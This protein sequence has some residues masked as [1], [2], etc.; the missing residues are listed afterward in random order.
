MVSKNRSFA[1]ALFFKR[2][3]TL[4]KFAAI[5]YKPPK[6]Q[7][8]AAIQELSALIEE[9]CLAGAKIIVC[10]EMATTGYI[11]S[12]PEELLPYTETVDGPLFQALSTLARTH[13]AWIVCGYAEREEENLYNAAMVVDS[14]GGLVCSYRKILLY[15]A[16]YTWSKSG[17]TRYL[18]RT[19]YGTLM[20]AICMDLNDNNLIRALWR[21]RPDI[22]AFCTNWLDEGTEVLPYWQTRLRGWNGVF[23]AANSWGPDGE[24]SFCGQSAILSADGSPAAQAGRSGNQILYAD[25]S[26]EPARLY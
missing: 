26:E 11:W 4:S 10:P 21:N 6:G 20:P 17:D 25:I 1:W 2:S 5:Q 7:P 15:D 12:S 13:G 8:A 23:L 22:V 24:I 9:A 19:E 3:I 14:G 16:D 18:I